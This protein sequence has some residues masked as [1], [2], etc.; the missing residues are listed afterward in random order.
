M[1]QSDL[2]EALNIGVG[3]VALVPHDEADAVLGVLAEHQI[4]AWVAGE[5]VAAEPG[6]GPGTVEL[7]G[8]HR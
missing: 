8:S 7:V 5:V 1:R 4:D 6:A 3:M 2:E